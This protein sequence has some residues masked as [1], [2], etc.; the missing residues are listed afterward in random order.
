MYEIFIGLLSNNLALF[1]TKLIVLPVVALMLVLSVQII[2]LKI[3]K[4]KMPY[5]IHSKLVFL[6]SVILVAVFVNLYWFIL[7]KFNGL[8]IFTWN[9]F[10]YDFTNIYFLL[11]PL[12]VTYVLLVFLYFNT[13]SKIKKLI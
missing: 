3:D 12:M 5:L 11:S 7:I 2:W 10:P 1:L 13:Q 6:K 8:F 9:Q 4:G